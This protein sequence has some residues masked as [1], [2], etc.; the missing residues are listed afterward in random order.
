MSPLCQ[1]LWC[2][3]FV[4]KVS[5]IFKNSLLLYRWCS[6]SFYKCGNCRLERTKFTYTHKVAE[7]V[8]GRA[9]M[10]MCPSDSKAWP[11]TTPGSRLLTQMMEA[12]VHPP[13]PPGCLQCLWGSC[14]HTGL[15]C[16]NLVWIQALS[17][18]HLPFGFGIC[19]WDLLPWKPT[20]LKDSKPLPF[21]KKD[22]KGM[23]IVQVILALCRKIRNY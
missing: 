6:L 19:S 11:L 3:I 14:P 17:L 8:R 2:S 18:P 12:Q 4:Y 1:A 13:L 15:D 10:P 22:E 5:L 20:P 16:I 7:L 21:L 9:R 23:V